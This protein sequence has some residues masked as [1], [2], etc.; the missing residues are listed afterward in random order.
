MNREL[1]DLIR[2][3]DPRT[4]HGWEQ[5]LRLDRSLAERRQNRAQ[6]D[7]TAR[8]QERVELGAAQGLALTGS[9]A[10]AAR[11]AISDLDYH[12]VG[13]RPAVADLPSD[14]D[15]YAG[16]ADRAWRKLRD[17]DDFVQWTLRRGLVLYDTGIFRELAVAIVEEDLWPSG[18]AKLERLPEL[19]RLARRLIAVADADAAQEQVRATLTSAARG[20]LLL[21]GVFPAARGELP[22]QLRATGNP[23]LAEALEA[24]IH[25]QLSLEESTESLESLAALTAAA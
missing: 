17:G 20:T 21:R 23:A 22:H 13:D 25:R 18:A 4:D 10:R 9:T 1:D 15:V 19:E 2:R 12:V 3:G 24:S 16:D 5:R 14:V 8:I 6:K 7:I 11:T